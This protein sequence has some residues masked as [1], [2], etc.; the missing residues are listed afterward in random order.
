MGASGCPNRVLVDVDG[1]LV[2]NTPF[3]NAVT[4]FIVK[5]LAATSR[6]SLSTAW[7]V[8]RDE[9][10]RTRHSAQWY[11][12]D[13]H[14]IRLGI[15]RIAGDAHQAAM[16][17][18]LPV[19]DALVTWRCF[20]AMRIR[21]EVV[22][23]APQWVAQFKLRKFGMTDYAVLTSSAGTSVT[24]QEPDF[25]RRL[26]VPGA[27]MGR[28]AIVDNSVENIAAAMTV[29]QGARFILFDHPEHVGTLDAS[30]AACRRNGLATPRALMRVDSHEQ[31][32]G[33]L[34]LR[35]R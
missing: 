15:G 30:V 33:A 1:V 35:E 34:G 7:S 10:T 31:L 13:F 22:T 11:D 23:D 25:W 4:E 2:D 28:V 27:E 6:I 32:R 19:C 26:L 8:W 18:L 5:Q 17:R 14:C 21:V 20:Q 12:Y 24:K 29:F 16:A 3:E 9:L